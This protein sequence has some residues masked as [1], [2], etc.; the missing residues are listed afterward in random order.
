MLSIVYM[1]EPEKFTYKLKL[2]Y[3]GT[4]YRGWQFQTSDT[5]TVQNY[6]EQ[7]IVK[8][9]K[10]QK[11]QVIAA[12][13]T[14]SGV[15]ASGQVLKVV[16]PREVSPE[17]LTRGMNSKLPNDIRVV[18]S[19]RIHETFNVNKDSK[20]KEY[21]YYFTINEE[22]NAVLSE[23]LYSFPENLNLE[24]MQKACTKIVGTHNFISFCYPGPKPPTPHRNILKCSIEKTRFLALDK[25]IY[26]LKIEGEGF[27]RY[28]VRYLMGALW[29][30]GLGK[31][32]IED[33]TLSL[34]TGEKHGV[35]TKA[36]SLGLH[37]MHIE[38]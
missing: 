30:I 1:N 31:L 2:S 20:F 16:L 33:F 15:H 4:Q 14:D 25:E 6:V 35:R 9:S 27:I 21:H 38:Y 10:H 12:S 29:D 24:L 19:E 34:S 36:P 22:E 32:S 23:I 13:R 3:R 8:I 18:S 11:F 28:M 17:N 37:L 26:Y 5:E 7:V